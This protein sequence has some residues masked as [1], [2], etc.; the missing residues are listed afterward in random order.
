MESYIGISVTNCDVATP[1]LM[2]YEIAR[3]Y[4]WYCSYYF[5]YD[6]GETTQAIHGRGLASQG[7]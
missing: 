1:Y 3:P 7:E 6:E 2:I 4:I 5:R